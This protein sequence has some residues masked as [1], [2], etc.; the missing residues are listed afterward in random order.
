M[1]DRYDALALLHEWVENEG[2]RKH[3]Y[4][5]EAGVRFY[6]RKMGGR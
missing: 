2:L 5:V 4:A 3:M 1:P 6:A